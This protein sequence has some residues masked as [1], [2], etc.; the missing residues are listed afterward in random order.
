MKTSRP[1]PVAPDTIAAHNPL[2]QAKSDLIV[3]RLEEMYGRPEWKPKLD[4]LDELIA[5]ILS[6]HT[7]DVNSFRAFER[8][9]NRYPTW[10]AALASE[11]V[12]LADTIRCGGLAD[13]KAP[14]IQGVLRAVQLKHGRLELAFLNDM[15]D[16]DARAYLMSLPGV[17]PKTA[18][19]VLCFALGRN[20][21]PVDTHVFRVAWRLGLIDKKIGEARAH[22][23]L[24]SQIAP[25]LTFRF[26]VALIQHGRRTCKAITPRCPL[27]PLTDICKFY[28]EAQSSQC[29][30]Q[31]NGTNTPPDAQPDHAQEL[32]QAVEGELLPNEAFAPPPI[33]QSASK[34]LAR[35]RRR[36]NPNAAA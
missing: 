15:T 33:P 8:L 26:H 10:E 35:S 5:C 20:V 32:L 21:L 13:S 19:I 29:G 24:Q 7:S 3:T 9:K 34:P 14:R 28:Q 22:D 17:G 2:E 31:D 23:A 30:D 11:T 25:D 36:S 18:A 12:E 6:Q 4:P 27:C 16:T 1:A